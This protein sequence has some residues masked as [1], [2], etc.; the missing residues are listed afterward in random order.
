VIPCSLQVQSQY[1]WKKE[2]AYKHRKI[3]HAP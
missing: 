2:E 3:P 1:E